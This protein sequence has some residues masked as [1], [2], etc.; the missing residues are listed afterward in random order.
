MDLP[1]IAVSPLELRR[2]LLVVI[3]VVVLV[4]EV[5]LA[6]GGAAVGGETASM[7]FLEAA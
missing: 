2:W 4:V 1:V 3:L 5:V 7:G 6:V